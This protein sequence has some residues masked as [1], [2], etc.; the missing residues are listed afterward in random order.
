MELVDQLT[1]GP[2]DNHEATDL[3][4]TWYWRIPLQF[5]IYF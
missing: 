3:G 4:G 1:V 5:Q 2:G